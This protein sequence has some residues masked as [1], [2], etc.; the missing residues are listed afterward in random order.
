MNDHLLFHTYNIT[1]AIPVTTAN[2]GI[3]ITKVLG[4]ACFTIDIDGQTTTIV[5]HECLYAPDAP[6]NLISA[7]A[8]TE[9][10]MYIGFGKNKTTCHFLKY[11][12][13]L[14]GLFF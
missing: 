3:L 2:C 7:G 14:Q 6:I 1:G 11:Y 5:L 8:L 4:K 12:K 10:E 9:N 13:S